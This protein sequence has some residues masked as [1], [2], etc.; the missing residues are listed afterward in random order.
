LLRQ[1][2]KSN[3]VATAVFLILDPVVDSS[4]VHPEDYFADVHRTMDINGVRF[5]V[6]ALFF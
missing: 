3:A 2:E 1:F 6:S 4:A 5:P